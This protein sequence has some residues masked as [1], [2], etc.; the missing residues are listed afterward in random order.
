MGK[1]ELYINE[2]LERK[3]A[4]L[5]SLIDP[6]DYKS[7]DHAVKTATETVRGGADLVLLGG[8][9][10]VQGG[11]LDR[12]AKA[13]KDEIDVPLVIFPGNIGTISTNVDAIYFMS[14]LNSRN[15]YW[16]TQAQMLA[17]PVIKKARI[18]PLPV[19]YIVVQPGGT[20]GWVGDTNFVPREKPMIAAALAV[21]GEFMGN[22]IIITDTGSNPQAHGFG[23]VPKEMIRAVKSSISVPYIVA[24]GVKDTT[25]LRDAYAAGAD[26]VQVGSAFES[27]SDTYKKAL[28]FSKVV[29]EEG[30]KRVGR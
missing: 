1:V 6:M 23:P 14:L 21:A 26:I 3:G 22:R 7:E 15:P 19:G 17:A 18:E 20:V 12:V 9:I 24:G 16:I 30:A 2:T 25:Q 10:G 28:S 27:I 29:K 13:I 4:M 11:I 8:S 5:F